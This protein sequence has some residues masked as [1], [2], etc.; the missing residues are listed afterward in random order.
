MI[1]S[2][3]NP[4]FFE[5]VVNFRTFTVHLKQRQSYNNDATLLDE[6]SVC[7]ATSVQNFRTST[8]NTVKPVL[9]GHSKK[10]PKLCF[11]D[12]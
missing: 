12:Q 10:D 9:S 7:P 1:F 11:Q 8:I 2:P 4:H 3:D 5:S 6:L